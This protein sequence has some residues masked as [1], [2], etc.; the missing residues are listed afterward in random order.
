MKYI[1]EKVHTHVG[2][3]TQV[4]V[5]SLTQSDVGITICKLVYKHGEY[6]THQPR[7]IHS[8]VDAP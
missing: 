6:D 1:L 4:D 5:W 7:L 3:H 2:M 8:Y